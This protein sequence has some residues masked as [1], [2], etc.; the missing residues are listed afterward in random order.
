MEVSSLIDFTLAKLDISDAFTT[1]FVIGLPKAFELV[2]V[3]T[4][5]DY[6]LPHLM[7]FHFQLL[8]L[9]LTILQLSLPIF[10]VQEEV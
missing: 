9:K 6:F 7:L 5:G 8:L 4:E 1:T 3:A 10:A 2:I